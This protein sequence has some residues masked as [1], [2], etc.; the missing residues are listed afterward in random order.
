M[1]FDYLLFFIL[2]KV[3]VANFLTLFFVPKILEN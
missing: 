2:E 1:E 3:V